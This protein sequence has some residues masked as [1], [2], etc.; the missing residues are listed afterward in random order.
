MILPEGEKRLQRLITITRTASGF[1]R[2]EGA[3]VNFVPM[4]SGVI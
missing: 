4:L 2:H 3:C 1:Q